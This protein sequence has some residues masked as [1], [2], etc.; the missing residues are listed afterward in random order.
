MAWRG[1]TAHKAA[2]GIA[3]PRFTPCT[4][5]RFGLS[6]RIREWASLG[7]LG[8]GRGRSCPTRENSRFHPLLV[9]WQR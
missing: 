6:S 1:G 9:P 3:Q 8:E 2:A 4:T 5:R 7:M